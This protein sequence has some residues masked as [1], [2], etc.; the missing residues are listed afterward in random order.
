ME[1]TDEQL[2]EDYLLNDKTSFDEIVNR[3]IKAIYNFV[4]RLSGNEKEAEDITQE[5]F[6]KVWKNI[7]KFNLE[8]SF[9]TWIFSIT[10]NTA[11]D[12]LRKRKDIPISFFDDENGENFLENTIEDK[13]PIANE[14]IDI[15]Y[16]KKELEK[17][18]QNLTIIQREVII[19]KYLNEMSLSEVAEILDMPKDTVKSHH[20]R[21]L[22]KM[23]SKLS[24]PKLSK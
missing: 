19:L 14:V 8:K 7:K 22:I 2:V 24:A 4:Y 11:I 18:M 13:E 15:Q 10:K 3:Y 20:R 21:A 12:Y 9:K 16:N 17:V 1:K 23:K 5:V 6:F